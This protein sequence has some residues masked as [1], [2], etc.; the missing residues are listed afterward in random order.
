MSDNINRPKKTHIGKNFLKCPKTT[1]NLS[2]FAGDA[3]FVRSRHTKVFWS[4][5]HRV[6]QSTKRLQDYNDYQTMVVFLYFNFASV[7]FASSAPENF[8][9]NSSALLSSCFASSLSPFL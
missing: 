2:V 3:L 1:H 4:R 7:S 6:I 9:S 8:G 5:S